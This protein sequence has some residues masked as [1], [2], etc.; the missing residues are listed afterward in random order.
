MYMCIADERGVRVSL[1]MG[2]KAGWQ[3]HRAGVNAPASLAQVVSCA[4]VGRAAV[5]CEV[6]PL[7]E[8]SGQAARHDGREPLGHLAVHADLK[9]A[10]QQYTRAS[11]ISVRS[12]KHDDPSC[13]ASQ[14]QSNA[15]PTAGH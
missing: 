7:A 6:A 3:A 14:I 9:A 15:E 13:H 5:D 10:G 8:C 2:M 1:K 4:V 12:A 11:Q